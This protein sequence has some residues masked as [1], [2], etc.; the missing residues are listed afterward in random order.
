[1]TEGQ[2]FQFTPY[3]VLPLG[4]VG[5]NQPPEMAPAVVRAGFAP[6]SVPIAESA[7]VAQPVAIAQSRPQPF[8]RETLR[9][10]DV[11]KAARARVREIKA[12]L[13]HHTRLQ[14]ELRQLQ[15]LLAAARIK[16]AADVKPL[17]RAV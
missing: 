13:K 16:P 9:P 11:L 14:C 10:A 6:V 12:E 8:K 3:G 4:A 15:N 7:P 17:R 2:G 5:G 1:M